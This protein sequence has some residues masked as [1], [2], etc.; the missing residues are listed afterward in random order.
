MGKGKGK[1]RDRKD[2]E[3][4]TNS[5]NLALSTPSNKRSPSKSTSKEEDLE[6]RYMK[7]V[8]KNIEFVDKLWRN[9][10]ESEKINNDT[11]DDKKSKDKK[12]KST[13]KQEEL[14]LF[15]SLGNVK[16]NV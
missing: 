16:H 12:S 3:A 7:A 1:K 2:L 9:E 10:A 15:S 4:I 5:A 14:V 11:K 6:E 8:E 13:S